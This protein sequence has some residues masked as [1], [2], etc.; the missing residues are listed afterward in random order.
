MAEGPMEI[1][2]IREYLKR[3]PEKTKASLYFIFTRPI[4][5]FSKLLSNYYNISS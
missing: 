1:V 4:T 5:N 3:S 2:Q